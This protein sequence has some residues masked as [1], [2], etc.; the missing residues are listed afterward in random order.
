MG[1]RIK[2]VE[3]IKPVTVASPDTN[4]ISADADR[5]SKSDVPDSIDGV[6]LTPREKQIFALLLTDAAAKQIATKLNISVGTYNTHTRNLYRKLG[7]Q[8]RIE[9]FS[10]YHR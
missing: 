1:K 5:E 7:I 2:I 8:S 3:A 9:L 10:K 6:K 4:S